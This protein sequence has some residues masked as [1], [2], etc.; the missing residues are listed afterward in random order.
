MNKKTIKTILKTT[1]IVLTVIVVIILGAVIL[2]RVS[3]NKITFLGYGI[4]TI[5]S[6]SMKPEYEIGD[7]FLAKEVSQEEIA[8]GD[9]LV[10]LGKGDTYE[11]K[12]ITHRVTRIDNKI[13]TQGLNNSIEEPAIEYD[14][15]YGRV[16]TKLALLSAFSKLMNN[17]FLFYVII[18]VPFT[19]LVFFDIKGIT[20]EKEELQRKKAAKKA[21][22]NNSNTTRLIREKN[23]N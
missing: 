19:I 2:Q 22:K 8:V 12:V 10:Y 3:N 4:Y 6:D 15:V 18:F 21:S 17:S 16:V 1:K 14:Q 23:A 7:M 9:D 5:V 13:H 20:K 11:D